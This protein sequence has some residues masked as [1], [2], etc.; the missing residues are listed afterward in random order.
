MA[1]GLLTVSQLNRRIWATQKI[2]CG[3]IP[4]IFRCNTAS[5]DIFRIHAPRDNQTQ[6]SASF[7]RVMRLLVL[8]VN[9]CQCTPLLWCLAIDFFSHTSRWLSE[10]R[11]HPQNQSEFAGLNKLPVYLR[12]ACAAARRAIGTRKG[13]QET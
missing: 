4:A 11:L 13:E 6:A 2:S 3:T 5:F 9:Q 10:M 1:K 12:A 8:F 7:V